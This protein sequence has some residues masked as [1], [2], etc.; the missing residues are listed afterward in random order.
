MNIFSLSI[1]NELGMN[2]EQGDTK[3]IEPH[4]RHIST[5]CVLVSFHTR[6]LT[7]KGFDSKIA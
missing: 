6:T 7:V 1:V 2:I 5:T 4:F 3:I